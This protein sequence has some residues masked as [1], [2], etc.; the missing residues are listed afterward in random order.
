MRLH[1]IPEPRRLMG[2]MP[3]AR[4]M[5][6]TMATDIDKA[7]TTHFETLR[8]L[9]GRAVAHTVLGFVYAMVDSPWLQ[10]LFKQKPRTCF[11][12]GAH[13]F[14]DGCFRPG[15]MGRTATLCQPLVWGIAVPGHHPLVLP[16][17]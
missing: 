3:V 8:L 9:L 2:A 4:D 1:P 6:N 12:D 11:P 14:V 7:I 17:T 10:A 13:G 5:A 15:P 16:R